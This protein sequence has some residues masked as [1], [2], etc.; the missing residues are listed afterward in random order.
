M[1]RWIILSRQAHATVHYRPRQGYQH[2]AGDCLVNVLL[3]ELPR[4]LPHYL[5]GFTLDAEG[6]AQPVALLGLAQGNNLYLHPDGRWLADYV[7]AAMRGYPFALVQ[8]PQADLS[9]GQSALSLAQ[10]ELL[11]EGEAGQPLMG[12][13]GQ[14]APTV[15]AIADFLQS[16]QHNRQQTLTAARQLA[17]ASLLTP[18]PLKVKLQVDE[19]PVPLTGLHCVD[20]Q[21]LNSL[22]PA[23][24]AALQG[25]AMALAHAQHFSMTN[26]EQLSR[27]A[28]FHAQQPTRDN[29]DSIDYL[30]DENDDN[31]SFDF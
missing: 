28:L 8:P 3:A 13:D 27:R 10:T 15:A 30:F 1:S 18:W 2:A 7:P 22:D 4:L 25:P 12:A 24:Y 31:I 17:E 23:T 29:T 16:C 21:R 14:L 6:A 26:T 9:E 5:L 11:T 20:M 19:E